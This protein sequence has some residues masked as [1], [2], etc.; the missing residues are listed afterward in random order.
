M[1][2]LSLTESII[3]DMIQQEAFDYEDTP[4]DIK[5]ELIQGVK[6]SKKI[7][8][9]CLEVIVA[10]DGRILKIANEAWAKKGTGIYR[11]FVENEMGYSIP[12]AKRILNLYEMQQK[13]P[14]LKLYSQDGEEKT[15]SDL[16]TH[17]ISSIKALPEDIQEKVLT[18]APLIDMN[19][20]Q[21]EKLAKKI[22][23]TGDY[24]EELVEEIR[25]KD[26]K[27]ADSEQKQKQ[28]QLEKEQKDNEIAE[29]KAKI[30][31]LEQIKVQPVGKVEP[32]IVEKI[33]EVE[34]EVIPEK[35]QEELKTL[36]QLVK[37]KNEIP[38]HIKNELFSLREQIAEKDT[39]LNDAKNTVEAIA[40]ATN[41]KFGTQ[42][43]DWNLLGDVISHFLGGASEYTYMGNVYKEES[44]NK[45]E[46][47]KT[48]VNKI[49]QWV[50]QMKQM[51][52]EN[53]T[54]GHTIY[55]NVS[56]E[57]ENIEEE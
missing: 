19:T 54:I 22:K 24:S 9:A 14:D 41:S 28:M 56:F 49:E 25:K 20:K 4:E 40:T 47:V 45:K 11:R 17:K 34:K 18:S 10:T 7:R 27:I 46:Y 12:T 15:L 51:M 3:G 6:D 5:M 2:N 43:V 50:L 53:L 39:L 42:K 36:R 23:E 16:G 57:I 32:E 52:N 1:E 44:P 37:E 8:S 33:V 35:V 21:V 13:F 31:E 55:D 48:Q 29:L 38:E 26:K 30:Q